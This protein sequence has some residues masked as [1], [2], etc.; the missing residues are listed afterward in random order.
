MIEQ[1]SIRYSQCAEQGRAGTD[2]TTEKTALC[3][4]NITVYDVILMIRHSD[5]QALGGIGRGTA[6]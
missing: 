2:S 6:T 5:Y 1:Y 4:Y 3:S